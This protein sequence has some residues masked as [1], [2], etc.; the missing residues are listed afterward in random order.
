LNALKYEE[1]KLIEKEIK[2][3]VEKK[4]VAPGEQYKMHIIKM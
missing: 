1:L 2:E 3:R 4:T